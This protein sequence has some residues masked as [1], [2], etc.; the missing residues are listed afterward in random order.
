ME[1][2]EIRVTLSNGLIV[3]RKGKN[4]D[5][6][7][8]GG[9][10][11]QATLDD[12]VAEFALRLPTFMA[13]AATEKTKIILEQ[14]PGLGEKLEALK[15]REEALYQERLVVGRQYELKQKHAADLPRIEGVPD[16][17]LTGTEM[18]EK[19]Q[20]AL[21]KNAE[22]KAARDGLASLMVQ[23][24][25]AETEI[26]ERKLRVLEL[27]K[28][29]ADKR[30]QRDRLAVLQP[31]L[32]AAVALV[33][34]A[35][36]RVSELERQLAEA[37]SAREHA[38]Q[39]RSA[40]E[41]IV[42]ITEGIVLTLPQTESAVAEALNRQGAATTRGIDLASRITNAQASVAGLKDEDTQAVKD[43][44][45]A[46]DSLNAQIRSNMDKEHAKDEAVVLGKEY[47]AKTHDI[48]AIRDERVKLLDG[49]PWPLPGM[50]IVDGELIFN[51]QKWDGM[52]TSERYRVAVA[53]C[54]GL[55]KNCGFVLVD[56]LESMDLDTLREFDAW[57]RSQDLQG[58]GTRVAMGPECD[59]IIEEGRLQSSELE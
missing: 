29:L 9:K 20:A 31:R 13:A 50:S 3:E 54:S 21:A 5:L 51:G 4:G 36:D 6:K 32:E 28:E 24:S 8:V 10:N 11:V 27:Q 43:Q 15:K 47:D 12:F 52:A 53:V 42:R 41:N 17:P 39:D 48:E 2:A 44:L 18:A 35:S 1:N 40:I 37:R 30:A 45:E 38:I 56:Q 19:L 33:V 25:Q 49:I 55:K 22:N 58:I 34:S 23:Q 26:T 7:I 59:I 57:L 16:E 14:F 46:I